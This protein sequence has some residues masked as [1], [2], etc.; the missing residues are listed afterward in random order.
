MNYKGAAIIFFMNNYRDKHNN[1][2]PTVILFVYEKGY[3]DKINKLFQR[4]KH[5]GPIAGKRD[6]GEQNPY[7]TI[8][9]ECHEEATMKLVKYIPKSPLFYHRG[10]PIFLGKALKGFSRRHWKPTQYPPETLGLEWVDLG[11]VLSATSTSNPK[12][13]KTVNVD[14]KNIYISKFGVR[15]VQELYQIGSIS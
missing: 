1:I 13:Y 6:R 10:T 11:N 9:R 12:L 8:S 4:I 15:L 7:V 2:H 5:C 14:K 3:Y